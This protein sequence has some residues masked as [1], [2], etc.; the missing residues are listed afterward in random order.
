MKAA[1]N[2]RDK[3]ARGNEAWPTVRDTDSARLKIWPRCHGTSRP[4]GVRG[5]KSHPRHPN[6]AMFRLA[7]RLELVFL[8][9]FDVLLRPFVAAV[10]ALVRVLELLDIDRY[11]QRLLRLR[12]AQDCSGFDAGMPRPLISSCSLSIWTSRLFSSV[13]WNLRPHDGQCRKKVFT[14]D[15]VDPAP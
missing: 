6:P 8:V 11:W 9:F 7:E 10:L 14:S 15:I 3:S 5:F 4:L 1:A 2:G 12:E 13:M